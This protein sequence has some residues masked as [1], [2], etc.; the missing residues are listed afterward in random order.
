[1]RRLE[2]KTAIVTGAGIGIGA[3]CARRLAAEGGQVVL[4]DID[5]EK[6][7]A[8]AGDIVAGG[9]DAIAVWLD[10]HNGDSIKSMIE[11]TLARYGKLDV[12]HNNAADT[13]PEILGRDGAIGLMDE[14]VW[15][16]TFQANARGTMLAIK[17][18]LPA[19]LAT[20]NSSIIN[21]SSGAA[22]SGDLYR[23]A[24]AASKAA[25]NALTL[26]VATQYGKKGVRCN[27]VSPGLIVTPASKVSNRE[28]HLA[29]FK[30]HTLTP[31]VGAPEDIAAMV[32]LL[33]SDDGR[34]VTGQVI[35][36]DGG[37]GSHFSH[38][39]DMY[40]QFWEQMESA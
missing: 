20:G 34:F 38:F 40:E 22:L 31:D 24:Y 18:A 27:V 29:Y 9:G 10:L 25:I 19:L 36:V 7:Q 39:A 6:A 5:L 30:R 32:A 8:V 33:A 17:H 28:E 21:T 37:I 4:A 13:R 14:V 26:Y 23:P 15:D 16:R 11:Q 12:L 1:L 35:A 3:A 2:G